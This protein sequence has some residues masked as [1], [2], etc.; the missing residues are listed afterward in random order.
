MKKESGQ[1]HYTMKSH[2][3]LV[4]PT[5]PDLEVWIQGLHICRP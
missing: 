2:F 1:V 3:V 4:V 5:F